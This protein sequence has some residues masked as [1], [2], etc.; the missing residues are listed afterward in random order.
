M[1]IRHGR[2]HRLLEFSSNRVKGTLLK[3][4]FVQQ[5]KLE[6]GPASVPE[7]KFP[8]LDEVTPD[9]DTLLKEIKEQVRTCPLPQWNDSST[10]AKSC[11]DLFVV[12]L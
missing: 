6:I 11:I 2:F 5:F 3:P 4:E 12:N 1:K 8:A 10:S 9:I 7:I